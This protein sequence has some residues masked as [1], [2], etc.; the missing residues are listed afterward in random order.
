M[1][2]L[3]KVDETTYDISELVTD[4]SYKDVLNNGCS[5]LEFK[6]INDD[7]VI[8]NGSIVSFK[9][10]NANIFYGFVFRV[11][12]NKGKEIS[13]T[14][15]DQLRYCKAKD[16]IVVKDDSITTLTTRMCNQ[17]R[18]KK[19][20][21]TDTKYVL[22]KTRVHEDKTWLDIIYT[23]ISDTLV[24]TGKKYCLRDEF[25]SIAIRYLEELQLN[26]ILGDESLAYDFG[27]EKSIDDGFYN[28]VKIRIKDTYNFHVKNDV[29]SVSKFG[30]LQYFEVMDSKTN[31][32]QANE[33]AEKLL[34][35]Y[36]KEQETLRL[37]C[38]GDTSI[39]AGASFYGLI[40]DIELNKRLIVKEV[41][42][43][44][45][46]NHTMSLEVMV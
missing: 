14:A 34:S 24:D 18:L 35:F 13:V 42:H 28:Q 39:C 23:T 2:F 27:Y 7:L 8:K 4:I 19:G 5:K 22:P 43:K 11:S 6:Y 15:Y 9:Y 44:F 20:S 36:N 46:P 10:N 37:E 33:K 40:S 26:L 38:L 25:G 12:R 16:T 30:T 3:I 17:L 31:A 1:E 45:L 41:T 32:S 29:N 21:I